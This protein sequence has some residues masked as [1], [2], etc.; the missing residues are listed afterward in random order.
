M[1]IEIGLKSTWWDQPPS[2]RIKFDDSLLWQGQIDKDLHLKFSVDP[3]HRLNSSVIVQ[4]HDKQLNQTVLA[5]GK[6]IKDQLL[7]IHQLIIDGISLDE[8]LNTSQYRPEYPEHMLVEAQ[9]SGQELTEVWYNVTAL[10]WNG[11]WRFDFNHPFDIWYLE[12]LP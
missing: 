6:I 4:L 1:K 2:V 5:D 10:G 3:Q 11:E 12:N 8:L 7:H 9:T